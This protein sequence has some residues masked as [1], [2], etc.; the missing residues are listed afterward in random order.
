MEQCALRALP[1]CPNHYI[2][3]WSYINKV[4]REN[5]MVHSFRLMEIPVEKSSKGNIFDQG[6]LSFELKFVQLEARFYYTLQHF[7]NCLP[8]DILMNADWVD[9]LEAILQNFK[10]EFDK[11]DIILANV[12]VLREAKDALKEDANIFG[13]L[14]NFCVNYMNQEIPCLCPLSDS[15]A[16][17]TGVASIIPR[18]VLQNQRLWNEIRM[19][20]EM[21]P[22]CGELLDDLSSFSAQGP[23]YGCFKF[24]SFLSVPNKVRIGL[25]HVDNRITLLDYHLIEEN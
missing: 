3:I 4:D 2:Q 25:N 1:G 21:M 24:R 20:P 11:Q 18:S 17:M 10:P 14:M 15:L 19:I 16:C 23:V 22:V 9:Q 5:E 7:L 13:A 8:K 12:F 6:E